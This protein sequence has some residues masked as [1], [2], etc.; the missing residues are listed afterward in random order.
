MAGLNICMFVVIREHI[1]QNTIVEDNVINKRPR[2]NQGEHSRA[3][4]AAIV[5]KRIHNTQSRSRNRAQ[6]RMHSEAAREAFEHTSSSD[7]PGTPLEG[8]STSSKAASRFGKNWV[9][10]F[11]EETN[12]R[13]LEFQKMVVES[14]L[15]S[16]AL[17][18]VM[19]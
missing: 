15:G 13:G 7:N 6:H 16:I 1:H 18:H 12:T 3:S 2:Q 11:L 19:P 8:P 14:I 17:Q 4:L 10:S 5:A 9:V